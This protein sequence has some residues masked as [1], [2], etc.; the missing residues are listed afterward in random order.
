[1]EK[2]IRGGALIARED[3]IVVNVTIPIDNLPRSLDDFQIIQISDVHIG[4]TIGRTRVKRVVDIVNVMCSGSGEECG[5]I[6]ITGDIIDGEPR[7]LKNA[8]EP[9]GE[10]CPNKIVPKLFVPGNHEHIHFIV[11][12]AVDVLSE[13]GIG[14]LINS[15]IRLPRDAPTE[16]QL[17]VVGLDDL[18]SRRNRGEEQEAFAGIKPE[19]DTVSYY[20]HINH[21]ISEW[22]KQIEWIS[23]CRATRM[24][25]NS[26]LK[27]LERGYLIRDT[28]AAILLGGRL[29][30][31]SRLGH[32]FGVHLSDSVLDIMK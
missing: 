14:H 4:V 20:L 21:T 2:K 1:M 6:A 23:C 3:P 24:R 28:L 13:M 22:Q 12:H 8:I 10:L 5:L 15:N 31:T 18:S 32:C 27:Q 17:T 26:S 11:H 25:G 19:S 29:P 30:C 16:N 9:L 7:G